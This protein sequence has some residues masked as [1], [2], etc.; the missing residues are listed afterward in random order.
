MFGDLNFDN[1]IDAADYAAASSLTEHGWAMPVA[2]NTL[3]KVELKTDLLIPGHLILSLPG[4]AQL[5]VWAT[6]TPSANDTP[7]PITGQTITNSVDGA[8]FGAYPSSILYVEAIVAISL[9]C[10][11]AHFLRANYNT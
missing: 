7:L 1:T 4:S 5:R 6:A 8:S 2:A 3:R 11:F 10:V 9:T